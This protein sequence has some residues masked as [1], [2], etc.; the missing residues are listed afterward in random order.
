MAVVN[1]KYK[2]VGFHGQ[3][4][5]LRHNETNNEYDKNIYNFLN[6]TQQTCVNNAVEHKK[7]EMKR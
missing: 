3:Y 7:H 1:T 4:E 5:S 2:Y 6:N